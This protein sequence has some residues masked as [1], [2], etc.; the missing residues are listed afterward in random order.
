MTIQS[1]LLH[2]ASESCETHC[3]PSAFALQLARAFEARVTALVYELDVVFP[4]S[5]YGR[6]I[7]AEARASLADRNSDARDRAS[8]LRDAAAGMQVQAEVLTERSFAYTIPEVVAD[9]ARLHDLTVTGIDARGL[10]SEHTIADYVLFQSGR[11]LIV[12]PADHVAPFSCDKVV[13]AWDYSR[14]AARALADA[15]PFLRR[16]AEVTLVAFG[17]DKEMESSL[18][19]DDVLIALTH[20]GVEARYEQAERGDR[21]IAA[22]ISAFAAGLSADLL[23]MGGYGHSRFREFV[24]GGAT[25]GVLEAPALPTFLSH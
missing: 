11:P 14:T 19:R 1:I 21:D 25:S 18:T 23:V 22:A 2:A 5:A 4:R 12:V 17:D 9:R 15:M 7:T 16:A 10:L 20:R 13:V 8:L 24:L 3:G 6:R